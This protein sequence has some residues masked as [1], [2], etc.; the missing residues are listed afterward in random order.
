MLV[1][2]GFITPAYKIGVV[3]PSGSCGGA[4]VDPSTLLHLFFPS[5]L[6]RPLP[7]EAFPPGG[8]VPIPASTFR[9]P[10]EIALDA[11]ENLNLAQEYL[12]QES[13]CVASLFSELMITHVPTVKHIPRACRPLLGEVLTKKLRN[14]SSNNIW[15]LPGCFSWPNVLLDL[16]AKVDGGDSMHLLHLSRAA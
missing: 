4:L 2:T 5:D 1:A 15:A 16:Q 8:N 9:S 11:V 7:F 14:A 6:A 10:L 12:G 13:E 3:D